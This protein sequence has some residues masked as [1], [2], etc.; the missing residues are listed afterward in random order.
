MNNLS[1]Y[2]LARIQLNDKVLELQN[3][4][5]RK[6]GLVITKAL[7]GYDVNT[8]IP[9]F[10]G[11]Q[12]KESTTWT[13]LL[14]RKLPFT[15]ITY[16]PASNDT[17]ATDAC[18]GKINL[19]TIVLNTDKLQPSVSTNATLRLCVFSSD[20]TNEGILAEVIDPNLTKVYNDIV[21]GTD[22]VINWDMSFFNNHTGE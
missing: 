7:A 21:E 16:D 9:K 6:L 3:R 10:F 14:N 15:G 19:S 4:G 2:G 22:C 5:T 8:D 20:L 11:I 17:S 12:L 1:Y 18:I 13:D